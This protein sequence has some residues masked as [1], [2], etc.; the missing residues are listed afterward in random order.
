MFDALEAYTYQGAKKLY[1][2]KPMQ[3]MAKLVDRLPEQA[4]NYV[5]DF[6]RA[7]AGRPTKVEKIIEDN[8]FAALP[9]S[10]KN[11]LGPRPLRE[12]ERVATTQ[13]YRGLL[14]MNFTAALRNLTQGINTFSKLGAKYTALGYRHL[15]SDGAEELKRNHVLDDIIIAQYR[16][17]GFRAKL[18][19]LDKA[20]F[21]LFELS[22]R[23]NR[24]AAYY[25]AKQMFLDKGLPEKEAIEAAKRVVRDTQFAYG[26]LHSPLIF[27]Q[28]GMRSVFQL[29]TFPLKQAEFVGGMLRHKEWRALARYII[30]SLVTV[31]GSKKIL[32]GI[33]N[34]DYPDV[35]F[36]NLLPGLGP[37][38]TAVVALHEAKGA[39]GNER[40]YLIKKVGRQ[41]AKMSIPAGGQISKSYIGLK[42][43]KEGESKTATGKR[44]FLVKKSR[45]NLIRAA[46]G[47][48]WTF[49][50]A[51]AYIEAGGKPMSRSK[52][53]FQNLSQLKPAQA[54]AKM[55]FIKKQ[56]PTLY[57]QIKQ[58]AVNKALGLTP[59]EEKLRNKRVFD[60][61]RARAIYQQIQKAKTP[62]EKATLVKKY[63]QA[64]IINKTVMQQLQMLVTEGK[65]Q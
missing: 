62:E 49:P 55:R 2:E 31:W 9:N 20:L 60:G 48:Q 38:P 53:M 44:R 12:V 54:S 59:E 25:G 39:R 36:K 63:T 23:I 17:A 13:V 22:E 35:L 32:G 11:I 14:G 3:K 47:G 65:L 21:A 24:G 56:N 41:V 5:D 1:L 10:W 61:S 4:A 15:L 37:I 7:Y 40:K 51:R 33:I 28:P 30:S 42:A 52:A 16:N 19:A 58:Q 64:G 34:L 8:V 50:E 26:K 29:S 27:Q 46:I 45:A 57:R 43:W 18:R 6:L